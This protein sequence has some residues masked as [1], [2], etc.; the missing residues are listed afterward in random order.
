MHRQG[1]TR[2]SYMQLQD[3]VIAYCIAPAAL[4]KADLHNT[5]SNKA[6]ILEDATRLES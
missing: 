3:R 1:T 5:V 2:S 4:C 6:G